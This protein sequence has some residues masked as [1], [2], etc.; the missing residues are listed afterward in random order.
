MCVEV[1]GLD[2]VI[3]IVSDYDVALACHRYAGRLEQ[4]PLFG[5]RGADL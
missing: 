2:A 3:L 1:E 5:T 4:A